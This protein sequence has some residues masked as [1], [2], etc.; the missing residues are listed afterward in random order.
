MIGCRVCATLAPPPPAFPTHTRFVTTS[1]FPKPPVPTQYT[2]S[3]PS[4][5]FNF[6]GA[7]NHLHAHAVA[8]VDRQ[9]PA[10]PSGTVIA[11]LSTCFSQFFYDF[12]KLDTNEFV[13]DGV[14]FEDI[15]ERTGDGEPD[16]CD[17]SA[18]AVCSREE[19]VPK[20]YP[21]TRIMPS[22]VS[23]SVGQ[24]P[25]FD[26]MDATR[27]ANDGSQFSVTTSACFSR[28]ISSW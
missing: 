27:A 18:V 5:Y 16:P 25:R 12:G 11:V 9:L 1:C 8:L 2:L 3:S 21:E 20:L 7:L 15:A 28:V 17:L 14:P 4:G 13:I 24:E 22:F 19:P 6:H 26:R 10:F 23:G